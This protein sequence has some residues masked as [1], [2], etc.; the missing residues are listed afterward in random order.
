[1]PNSDTPDQFALAS[2]V[3]ELEIQL[4]HQQRM[5]EQLDA[6]IVDQAQQIFRLQ[7]TLA[8]FDEQLKELR[9]PSKPIVLDLLDEKPPHY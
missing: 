9:Q 6:V 5:V 8:R 1:M 4:M 2:R 7:R 3:T